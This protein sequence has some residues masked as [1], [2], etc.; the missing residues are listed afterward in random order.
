[1]L[2]ESEGSILGVPGQ[3][4]RVGGVDVVAYEYPSISERQAV[5][6]TVAADGLSISGVSVSWAG[7]PNIWAQGRLIVLYV[8]TDGG[9]IVLLSGLLG[10]P[11]TGSPPPGD[12]PYPPGVTAAIGTLADE[13]GIDPGAID[14]VGYEAVDW[15]DA[16]LGLPR[17]GEACA[18]VVIP[19]WR[20][21][22]SAQGTEHEARS[23][24]MGTQVRRVPPQA[25]P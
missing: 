1:M 14:V 8:G 24:L 21:M 7:R 5:S 19:G 10:D 6:D 15:P 25:A 11:I 22:M 3:A 4:L 13:L 17:A 12:E 20:V 9:T 16:C 23:D 2:G 18:E